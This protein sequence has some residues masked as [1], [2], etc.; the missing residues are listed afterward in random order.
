MKTYFDCYACF[1]KQ[2]LKLAR[3]TV[4]SE[5][6][7]K[8]ILNKVLSILLNCDL[9]LTPPLIA[10]QIEK[11]I[12]SYTKCKDPYKNLKKISNDESLKIYPRMKKVLNAS[13]DKLNTALKISAFGNLID[14]A[15]LESINLKKEL[16]EF[17]N[18]KT[19]FQAFK[20]FSKKL[21]QAQ[22]ILII[23]DN[24]GEIVFDKILI[25]YLKETFENLK[26]Y[27]AVRGGPVIND[28]I[29]EDAEY[30]GMDKVCEVIS[31]GLKTPGTVI[32]RCSKK[33]IKIFNAVDLIISKG[34]GNYESLSNLKDER[35]YYLLKVKCE[36][37]SKHL[38]IEIG[39]AA[40]IRLTN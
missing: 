27:F 6:C 7:Q 26:I 29:L 13:K 20:E 30:V 39:K 4:C 23:G 31:N 5:T 36:V 15:V 1:I 35:I 8:R 3:M 2:T 16:L 14:F 34:Q 24:A 12:H 28:A 9:E 40:M 18:F 19:E 21:K 33:F 11:I 10:E 32:E 38:G 25:E 22:S 17:K 37:V